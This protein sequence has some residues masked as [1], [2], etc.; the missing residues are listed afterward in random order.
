M[1]SSDKAL[2]DDKDA[3]AKSE[4]KTDAPT[5]KSLA[6]DDYVLYAA[7]NVLKGAT[8]WQGKWVRMTSHPNPSL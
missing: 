5:E 4:V 3:A 1:Q 6:E 7:L 2:P 8:F